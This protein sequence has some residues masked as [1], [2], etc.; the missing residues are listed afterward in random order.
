MGQ[1]GMGNCKLGKGA[2]RRVEVQKIQVAPAQVSQMLSFE[3]SSI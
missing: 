1:L 2:V 3:G